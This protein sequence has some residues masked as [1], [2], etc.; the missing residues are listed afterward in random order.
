VVRRISEARTPQGYHDALDDMA[1][2]LTAERE[3]GIKIEMFPIGE[4]VPGSELTTVW[5]IA[6]LT[7]DVLSVLI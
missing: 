4:A 7:E 1:F 3:T 5:F 6:D 2:Y